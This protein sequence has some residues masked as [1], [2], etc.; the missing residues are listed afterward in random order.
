MS[1][2]A[3]T[4]T[5][6]EPKHISIYLPDEFS[7]SDYEVMP[8]QEGPGSCLM[9]SRN[10]ISA[11]AGPTILVY[12]LLDGRLIH[13]LVGHEKPVIWFLAVYQDILVTSST[14]RT[15]RFWD[16]VSGQCLHVSEEPALVACIVKPELVEV[17]R[18]G[19]FTREKWPQKPLIVTSIFFRSILRITRLPYPGERLF[20][21]IDDVGELGSN[22][23]NF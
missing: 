6:Q 23:E 3:T 8:V 12:S 19:A 20:K 15:V 18:S 2:H 16:L 5:S 10:H 13:S 9:L 21:A 1:Q 7:S 22:G 14:D 4:W 11:A 17:E